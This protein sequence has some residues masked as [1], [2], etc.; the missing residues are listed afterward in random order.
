MRKDWR[1]TA[2]GLWWFLL[3]LFPTS[4]FPLNE[5][6]ND[7]RMYFPFVGLVL[8]VSWTVALLLYSW[9]P[10]RRIRTAALLGTGALLLFVSALATR[11]R[12][13]VWR[14]EESLWY[15]VTLKSPHNGRG[16]MNYGLTQMEKGDYRRAEDYFERAAVYTP[17]YS[18]LEIN[19]GIANGG[20]NQDAAAEEHFRR[21]ATIAPDAADS[22][23]FY[24]RWLKE[25][26]RSPEA[27]SEL[28]QAIAL[29]ADYM[30]AQYLIME[31]YAEHGDWPRLRAAAENTLQRFP[32]DATARNFLT[33]ANSAASGGT[34]LQKL[35]GLKADDYINISLAF[36]RAGKFD[37][38]INAAKEALKL[39]PN[40]ATAYNNIAAAYAAMQKWDPAIEAARQAIKINPEFQLARN[41]LAWAESQKAAQK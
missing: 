3:A 18:N 39:Q 36:Y 9:N 35:P 10:A 17:E 40:Y 6:E 32:A 8:A 5:V 1:P 2:F 14:T 21:A 29:N 28:E 30:P 20:L 33:R 23:Y 4:I 12:N 31:T 37:E 26:K 22:H 13:Q 34:A 27:V 19:L 15:D 11:G 38:C 25:K 7:H 41:N 16:L 24:A